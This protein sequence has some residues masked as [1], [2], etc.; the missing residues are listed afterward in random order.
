MKRALIAVV[1]A[2]QWTLRPWVGRHCRFEPTCSDYAIEALETHGAW[3]GLRLTLSRLA[4][5]HPFA[6]GGFDPVP[7]KHRNGQDEELNA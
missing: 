1:K 3:R 6:A 7:P 2:Y 5:C 4:R